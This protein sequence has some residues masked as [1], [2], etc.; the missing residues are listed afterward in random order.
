[1]PSFRRF[2]Y[3]LVLALAVSALSSCTPKYVKLTRQGN[4]RL[5]REDLGGA[6]ARFQ[7]AL[8]KS[9]KYA[10]ALV[11]L[12]RIR[13]ELRRWDQANELFTQTIAADPMMAEAYW[14]RGTARLYLDQLEGALTDLRRAQ[15][16]KY[17][18]VALGLGIAL[19]L[20]SDHVGAWD[21]LAEAGAKD[22][23]AWSA[24]QFL[25]K[26]ALKSGDLKTARD[27]LSRVKSPVEPDQR[28]FPD[29]APPA[30]ARSSDEEEEED[31]EQEAEEE[32]EEERADPH[33]KQKGM[34]LLKRIQAELAY[35][36]GDFGAASSSLAGI[37]DRLSFGIW[38]RDPS[39]SFKSRL[40]SQRGPVVEYVHLGSPAATAGILPGDVLTS[41]ERKPIKSAAEFETILE[42]YEDLVTHD[43]A[44][45]EVLRGDQHLAF[46]MVPGE[47]RTR[48][49][50]G[51]AAQGGS[52]MKL[53]MAPDALLKFP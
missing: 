8:K 50:I 28:F 13:L 38:F 24:V 49:V 22:A 32:E 31:E 25:L 12:G 53:E 36:D 17:P 42:A 6:E 41:F 35:L 9:P 2:Y 11:K 19:Y 51:N 23:D 52:P 44:L 27:L 30:R 43:D 3:A 37:D 47:F 14:G 45:V 29:A 21:A 20:S 5:E 15:E 1:M 40:G 18:D 26:N 46:R 10:P 4:V 33:L 34:Q 16:M 7:K 48:E 39:Q